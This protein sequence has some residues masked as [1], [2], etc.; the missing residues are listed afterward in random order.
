LESGD[1][2]VEV[3]VLGVDGADGV[4][5]F[6]CLV[7]FALLLEGEGKEVKEVEVG[8]CGGLSLDEWGECGGAL[9]IV[10]EVVIGAGEHGSR[11][12][13][14][15]V[16]GVHLLEELCGLIGFLELHTGVRGAV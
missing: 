7:D 1:T 14:V 4:E 9:G 13:E 12:G 15:G 11:C 8:G 2:F 10:S 16:G 6:D 3:A 5:G